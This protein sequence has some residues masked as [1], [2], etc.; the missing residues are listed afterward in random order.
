MEYLELN[1]LMYIGVIS[2][3]SF[4]A[5]AIDKAFAIRRKHRVKESTFFILSILGGSAAVYLAMGFFNH[6]TQKNV[7]VFIIPLIF[8]VQCVV[9]W[10]IN[11]YVFGI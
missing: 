7:F 3:V 2:L 8:A 9:V 10:L 4:F 1:T 6:K 11:K 5:V